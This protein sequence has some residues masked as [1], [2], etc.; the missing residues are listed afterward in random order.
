MRIGF[1]IGGSHIA[2]GMFDDAHRRVGFIEEP[3]PR[4]APESVP[5]LIADM[6]AK[7]AA[8][9]KSIE[10]VGLAVPG[11]IDFARGVVL[12]AYNLGFHSFPLKDNVAALMPETPVFMGNDADVAALAELYAGAFMGAQSAVLLTL[13]T[14]LGGGIILRGRLFTGGMGNGTETGHFI[15]D[16]HGERCTCGSVGCSETVCSATA[17]ARAGAAAAA[18]ARDSLIAKRSGG[19]AAKIDARTVIDCAKAGDPTA[20]AVFDEYTTALA[21]AAVSL[22][23]IL[24]PE[25]IAFGG[26]VSGAGDFLLTP[27]RAKVDEMSFFPRHA[28]IELASLGNGAGMLGAALL[29][30]DAGKA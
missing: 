22:I 2:G 9:K 30:L 26:G 3:F 6:T 29:M 1:D 21:S 14:G 25:V 28:R 4:E 16:M 17:L 27:V 10:C 20:L 13:G 19:D 15:L 7:L 11:S 5:K 24:D 23:H 12:H 8:G 18:S